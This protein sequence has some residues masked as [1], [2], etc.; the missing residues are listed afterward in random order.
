MSR[1]LIQMTIED[2]EHYDPAQRQAIIDSYQPHEREA[3][4]KGIPIMGS[5][6]VFPVEESSILIDPIPIPVHW[7][8]INGLDFGWDHPFG[9]TNCAWDREA[10]CFY[11][12]KEYSERE[13]TPLIHAGAIKPW[14][15]WIPCAWP[16]DGLQHDKG[17][18][19]ALRDQYDGHG[20]N[21]LADRATFEDG[22]NGLEAG[23]MD[24]LDR[25]QTARWKVFKTCGGWIS[26]F[27]LYHRKD[28][29]IV[30]L[31]D[32]LISSSRYAL[33]MKRSAKIKPKAYVPAKRSRTSWMAA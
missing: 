5:G 14:G 16:H 8:Q 18:G 19:E 28:G 17:S 2:A 24:M 13:K 6:R 7:P 32:D 29:L 33:M 31:K 10:D 23:I 1:G 15:D 12:C 26:E 25:M 11:V 9:A 30:K 4:T 27:R 3:R 22:S 20:L 21:M